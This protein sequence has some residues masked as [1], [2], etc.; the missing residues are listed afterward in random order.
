M[1]ESQ[2]N[3]KRSI[4]QQSI[5][6]LFLILAIVVLINVLA[7]FA[8][9]RLD[10]TQ[11]KRYSLSQSSKDLA[12][13]LDDIVYFKIYLAGDL[14]PG[15]LK[16]R[17]S[18]KEMLDEF[19]VYSKD[20][21]E[22]EFIDPNS[23]PNEKERVELYKQLSKK[24][25]Y[26]TTLEENQNGS[27]SQKLIF[28]GAIVNFRSKEI[29][30]QI[31]K[32]KLGSGSDE[33]LN[34]SVENL[35][36][37]ISSV[38]RKISVEKSI[39]VA[40]LKGQ[41]EL[42]TSKFSD[43][44]NGLKDYYIVDTVSIGGKINALK[45][46]KLLI[47]PKPDTAFSEKDKFV[48]DQFVM[49]GGRVLWL[50]DQMDIEMDSLETRSTTMAIPKNL[51]LDDMLFKY[52]VRINSDLLLDIQAAPI[53]VI[54]GYVGN[55]PKQELFPWYYF[56]L[57][58]TDSKNPIVHNLNLVKT[59]FAS[60]IDTIE[61]PNV[62]K[63]VL[64]ATSKSSRTQSSPARV[65]L[66]ILR[67]KPEIQ[68]FNKRNIPVAILLEGEFSSNFTNRIPDE[69]ANSPEINFQK[70]SVPTKMIVV[71]DGD[72]IASHISKKGNIYPLGYDRFTR[73]TFGNRNFIL[74]CVDYLL[75]NKGVLELRSKEIK[76]R[77]LD[78]EK[79]E[80]PELIKW[81]NLL[82]PTLMVTIFGILFA[83][84]RKRKFT[85]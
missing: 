50:I 80:S 77:L 29:P 9:T 56:P 31:L 22:Y 43:A 37:E 35:E 79:I 53:P 57:L 48:I 85:R 41:N 84:L 3:K 42:S 72:V 54:T 74:N 5:I 61:T 40:F 34:T 25:L 76:M 75:D 83:F 46:F 70:K 1:V 81:T 63:T 16:L 66:N 6:Q 2:K 13:H 44:A 64:L 11:E 30:M 68:L 12:T 14:P 67:D 45:D 39:S 82:L 51:N 21:I 73:Q 8:F 52:G 60:S 15:F 33:M 69:I 36:Y 10:M 32:S 59:E 47:I 23:N 27:Q 49:N 78:P 4:K 65:S 71:S 7:Q 18:L 26:P 62:Q 19:R 55:Q 38:L 17:N 58:G 20:N 28:P 24:G